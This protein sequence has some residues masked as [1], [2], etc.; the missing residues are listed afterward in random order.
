MG[1][2]LLFAVVVEGDDQE[3]D[4]LTVLFSSLSH[5]QAPTRPITAHLI[6]T[7]ILPQARDFEASSFMSSRLW[8]CGTHIWVCA[9][10]Q[11]HFR[12][13]HIQVD[14]R[15]TGIVEIVD[16]RRPHI[17]ESQTMGR[18]GTPTGG[19]LLASPCRPTTAGRATRIRRLGVEDYR[20]VPFELHL[21]AREIREPSSCK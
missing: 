8:I 3:E 10:E 16:E 11:T 20:H 5:S 1:Q 21:E 9:A 4:R 13:C 18:Q 12:C 15:I 2:E 6:H 14:V 7:N 17:P 19:V